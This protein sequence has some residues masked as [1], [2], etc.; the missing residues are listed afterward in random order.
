MRS[1]TKTRIMFGNEQIRR[2]CLER[3]VGMSD[4]VLDRRVQKTRQLLQ[5]GLT[6]LIYKKD[7][8]AITVQEILDAANV[9]R[10]TF[11]AH[12][13][14]KDQ[15]LHSLL[16]GLSEM[17]AALLSHLSDT[18]IEAGTIGDDLTLLLFKVGGQNHS[19]F[20]IFFGKHGNS[21]YNELID[22][23]IGSYL[24]VPMQ[25]YVKMLIPEQKDDSLYLEMAA[26]YYLSAFLGVLVWWL[27]KDLPYTAEEVN[28]RF[29][30]LTRRGFTHVLG[31]SEPS[32]G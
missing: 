32:K 11:Y 13:E 14:N 23:L 4:H 10:S 29:Q 22:Q 16:D 9:G 27:E 31:M 21:K 18:K 7:Y 12:F 24:F 5:K 19:L 17:L 6:Q 2:I 30:D 8:D 20:K 3:E 15:L 26:Q 25:E 28:R 1:T